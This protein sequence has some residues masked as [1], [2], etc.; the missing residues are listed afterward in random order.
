[1]TP[2]KSA[3]AF[4]ADPVVNGGSNALLAAEVSLGRVVVDGNYIS[5]AGVTASIDGAL[6]I[7]AMLRGD[8]AARQLRSVR[9]LSGI[10]APFG[11]GL[12]VSPDERRLYFVQVG[13]LGCQLVFRGDYS[14][15]TEDRQPK[16]VK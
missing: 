8:Q 4:D 13:P 12:A 9:H 5:A 14:A 1:M 16:R 11:A 15:L 3:L 7:A 6:T 2:G 10:A